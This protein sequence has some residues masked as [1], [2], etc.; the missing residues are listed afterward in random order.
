MNVASI[1][2]GF[3]IKMLTKCIETCNYASNIVHVHFSHALR[4]VRRDVSWYTCT[5]FAR[6][7]CYSLSSFFLYVPFFFLK[8]LLFCRCH[9]FLHASF[10]VLTGLC[11]FV[12]VLNL[13][14]LNCPVSLS[15]L[16]CVTYSSMLC[17]NEI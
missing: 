13:T 9:C 2:F 10:T 15:T 16:K 14:Y 3:Y 1:A 7:R 8:Q 4:F 5:L 17:T 12:N 6:V 11:T